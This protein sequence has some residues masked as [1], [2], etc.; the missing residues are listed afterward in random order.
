MRLSWSPRAAAFPIQIIQALELPKTATASKIQTKRNPSTAERRAGF[1]TATTTTA[2]L[3]SAATIPGITHIPDF[4][5]VGGSIFV[6][7]AP[8]R[9]V[10]RDLGFRRRRPISEF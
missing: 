6:V 7:I 1:S 10:Y 4:C 5:L 8:F 3:S 9:L 2:V